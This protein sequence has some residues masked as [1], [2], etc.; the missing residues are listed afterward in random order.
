MTR[1]KIAIL[2][3]MSCAVAAGCGAGASAVA[4]SRGFVE[5][6]GCDASVETHSAELPE[7][8]SQVTLRLSNRLGTLWRA[9]G[10]SLV[11]DDLLVTHIHSAR[12]L[13]WPRDVRVSLAPGRHT[14]DVYATFK[15]AISPTPYVCYPKAYCFKVRARHEFQVDSNPS[16]DPTLTVTARRR[17]VE[18]Y[19]VLGFE[20][21]H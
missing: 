7:H 20:S 4:P 3:L 9:H 12:G 11:V 13:T 2:T 16:S 10:L 8:G 15:S 14:L 17:G 5:R 21:P 1:G 19:P 6:R 18:E